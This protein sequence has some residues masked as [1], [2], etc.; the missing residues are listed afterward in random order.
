MFDLGC[1][2]GDVAWSP[3]SSTV[4]AAVTFDG[5]AHIF[6]LKVDKY[7]PICS[8]QIVSNKRAKLNH[9]SFNAYHP[10]MIVGDSRSV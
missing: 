1:Q 2:V 8:Q 5:K 4:F 3:S 10:T 6:D 9:V 7:H